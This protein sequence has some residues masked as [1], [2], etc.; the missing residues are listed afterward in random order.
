V[1]ISRSTNGR[2]TNPTKVLTYKPKRRRNIG[3]PHL[4][5]KNQHILQ[6]DRKDQALPNPWI[7]RWCCFA[8]CRHV[9][10]NW[11]Y[12]PKL[13]SI[14]SMF[15]ILLIRSISSI[16]SWS[17]KVH[18]TVCVMNFNS[19]AVIIFCRL[20]KFFSLSIYGSAALSWV[21]AAFYNFLILY[22]V[23]KTPWTGD[24][25]VA[26]PLPTHRTTQTQNKRTQTSMPRVGFETK[27]PAFEW[28]KTVQ[29]LDRAATVIGYSAYTSI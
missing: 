12:I 21:L 10:S 16:L 9:E 14:W 20:L 6:E 19:G 3:R 24:Q 11:F 25:P 7:W 4:R 29:A 22:T 15:L 18:L 23:G 13:Y 27:L 5:R 17:I 26:R 8:F 2:Q 1:E 28:A